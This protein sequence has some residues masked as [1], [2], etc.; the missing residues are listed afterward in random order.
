MKKENHINVLIHNRIWNGHVYGY[1]L[2]FFITNWKCDG[3]VKDL[4]CDDE[5]ED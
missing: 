1:V 4:V 5:M 2:N 3:L